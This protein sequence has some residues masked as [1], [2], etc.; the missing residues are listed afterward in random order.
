MTAV[1]AGCGMLVTRPAAQAARTAAVLRKAG[2]TV[3][4]LPLLSLTA[5]DSSD[6]KATL[7]Q[8]PDSNVAIFVSTNA[9]Q[10][11]IDALLAHGIDLKGPTVA[12]IG[13]ATRAALAARGVDATIYPA[14]GQDS[15]GLLE[16]AALRGVKDQLILLFR[17][18]SASGGRR[19]LAETLVKRGARVR[20]A[21]CYR[22]EPAAIDAT[23]R[24]V[25]LQALESGRL[26]VIQI[27]S[28]ESLEALMTALPTSAALLRCLVVV[29]HARIAAAATASGFSRVQV[30]DL[31][32]DVMVNALAAALARC[33]D[34]G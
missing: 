19:L 29:P 25:V 2:A 33:D 31:G 9:A 14:H 16:H 26:G 17:G 28:V 34:N 7:V 22:R 1:L 21:I 30:T 15:E 23:Q 27:M 32:D 20:E 6:L 4:E 13:S 12:A 24:M 10:F 18:D 11:G 5:L 8:Y 3:F